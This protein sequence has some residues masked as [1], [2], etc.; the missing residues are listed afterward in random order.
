MGP[1]CTETPVT[2]HENPN[3]EEEQRLIKKERKKDE[4]RRR[5]QVKELSV[6]QEMKQPGANRH[7]SLTLGFFF[8]WG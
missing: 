5:K 4:T 1:E 3:A 6:C 2:F 8:S 7:D